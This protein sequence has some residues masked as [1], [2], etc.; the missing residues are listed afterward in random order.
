MDLIPIITHLHLSITQLECPNLSSLYPPSLLGSRRLY[1]L[2]QINDKFQEKKKGKS[3]Q[4]FRA[5]K[6]K[7]L[8]AGEHLSKTAKAL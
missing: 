6:S 2:T 1:S 5:Q 3:T 4:Q 7:I 8:F